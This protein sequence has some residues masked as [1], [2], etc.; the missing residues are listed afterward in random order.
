MFIVKHKEGISFM[1][2]C[3]GLDCGVS[4]DLFW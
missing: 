2:P 3:R 4:M 1:I